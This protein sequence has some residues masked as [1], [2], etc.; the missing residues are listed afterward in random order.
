MKFSKQ[1][2]ALKDELFK[3][4]HSNNLIYNTCWED[5]RCD[6]ALMQFD[7]Q[8]EIV[9][10][11]SAG[12]NALDYL[13][14]N[15]KKIHC[16]DLNPKQNA[17][18]EL[19]KSF[20]LHGNYDDLYSFFSEGRSKNH[21]EIYK[22]LKPHLPE[23][24]QKFWD[25]KIG[26]F[27]PKGN[28]KTFYFRGTSGNFAWLFSKYLKRKKS[29]ESL[30]D[31]L[32]SSKSLDEQQSSYAKLEPKLMTNLVKWLMNRHITMSLLGVPRSQRQLILDQYPGGIAAYLGDNLR[33]VFTTLPINE[34]YFWYLYLKGNY[35]KNCLPN[36]LQKSNFKII[37][38]K[39][40]CLSCQNT[41]I[42]EFLRNNPGNYT[43]FILLDHQDW[44][45]ANDQKGLEDEWNLIFQNAD[46][47]AKILLRSAAIEVDFLPKFVEEKVTFLH[48]EAQEQHLLDRVGTYGSCVLM[49]VN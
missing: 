45:A 19:K 47:G 49:Q 17:L 3:K 18:L 8:S 34:N 6:R 30:V 39:V 16:I 27:N 37:K 24:A 38:D 10:I 2:N 36:Y 11:S 26:Y 46:K 4:V 15:P 41:S 13:L 28:K 9:M 42:A 20:Y 23:Y 22:N 35:H 5:P 12:C 25:E 7:A 21:L 1:L 44:L 29:I 48:K 40:D 14:D 31:D 32:L 33:R 43:H